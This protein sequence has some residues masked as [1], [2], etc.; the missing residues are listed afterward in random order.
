M[1]TGSVQSSP[2]CFGL[3]LAWILMYSDVF[4]FVFSFSLAGKDLHEK[5]DVSSRNKRSLFQCKNNYPFCLLLFLSYKFL[6]ETKRKNKP[7]V[8]CEEKKKRFWHGFGTTVI[9]KWSLSVG[10]AVP[11]RQNICGFVVR[12]C[13]WATGQHQ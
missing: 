7:E 10:N 11:K 9:T 13:C 5:K 6:R 4:L 8:C 3:P 12:P 2:V 1:C